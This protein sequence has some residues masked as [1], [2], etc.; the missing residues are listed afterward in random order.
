MPG[1]PANASLSS[2][3]SGD[4]ALSTNASNKDQEKEVEGKEP[5]EEEEA[6]THLTKDTVASD[7]ITLDEEVEE[8]PK[9]DTTGKNSPTTTHS[10]E[11]SPLQKKE[12]QPSPAEEDNKD[13]GE[14]N[15]HLLKTPPRETASVPLSPE[16][17]KLKT[18][19][20]TAKKGEKN[21]ID[22]PKA[23]PRDLATEE[24]TNTPFKDLA[25]EL[26]LEEEEEEQ[27]LPE[28]PVFAQ[29]RQSGIS[30]LQQPK[31]RKSRQ[32]KKLH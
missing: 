29:A 14:N 13:D 15:D 17:G 4:Q 20:M 30:K 8:P 11:L 23:P 10:N 9:G 22:A 24:A 32:A 7:I 26:E 31:E 18:S 25:P 3:Q 28:A 2:P 5:E 12:T 6:D 19:S 1:K 21:K 27:T 16:M